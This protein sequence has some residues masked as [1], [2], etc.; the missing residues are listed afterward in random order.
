[1]PLELVTAC[2]IQKVFI[3]Y[4]PHAAA[5]ARARAIEIAGRRSLLSLALQFY[6][7]ARDTIAERNLPKSIGDAGASGARRSLVQARASALIAGIARDPS[8]T[9]GT[10]RTA[11]IPGTRIL[12][13]R[14][15]VTHS[16]N[17]MVTAVE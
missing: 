11:T 2:I 13:L 14:S 9:E 16:R 7:I 4:T 10:L 5:R 17:L 12:L 6:R 1:M 3:M 15:A 8:H